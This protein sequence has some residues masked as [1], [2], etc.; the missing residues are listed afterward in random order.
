[1]VV[2]STVAGTNAYLNATIAGHLATDRHGAME[3]TN[4]YTNSRLPTILVGFA[5]Y[6]SID[7][8]IILTYP[9]IL[10]II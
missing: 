3:C 5:E 4:N 10:M 2:G 7:G 8:A 9:S 1:M 6:G